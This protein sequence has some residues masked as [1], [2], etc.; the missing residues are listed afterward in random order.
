VPR[1]VSQS[2]VVAMPLPGASIASSTAL[3]WG[4]VNRVVPAA[5]LDAAAYAL[6]AAIIDKPAA[7]V[8]LG[9]R[10]FYAQREERIEKAY[11]IAAATITR[12][13]LG[14]DAQEGVA[15]F[16]EKRRPRWDV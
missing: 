10:F 15:A 12:N 7:V 1:N 11:A 6:A 14:P 2:L 13:M 3:D 5:E 8:A 4:L 16:V 9:K